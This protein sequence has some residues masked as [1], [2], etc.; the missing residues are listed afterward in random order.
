M[1]SAISTRLDFSQLGPNPT[2]LQIQA[3]LEDMSFRLA[4]YA[5][6]NI[7]QKVGLALTINSVSYFP[8]QVN[9]ETYLTCVAVTELPTEGQ[10]MLAAHAQKLMQREAEITAGK[11]ASVPEDTQSAT[12]A[13]EVSG[14]AEEPKAQTEE[15]REREFARQ[16]LLK[17]LPA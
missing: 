17:N 1:I 13:T 15:E 11:N 6:L 9:G 2:P 14:E 16:F 12:V 5:A 10:N 7:S 8:M 3:S 4:Q